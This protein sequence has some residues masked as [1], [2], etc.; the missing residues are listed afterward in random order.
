[1]FNI[2]GKGRQ[3]RFSVAVVQQ[4]QRH[5]QVLLAGLDI[6]TWTLERSRLLKNGGGGYSQNFS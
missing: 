2:I 3:G 6:I 4:G 5:L 1:L